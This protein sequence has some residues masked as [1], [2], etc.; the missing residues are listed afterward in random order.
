MRFIPWRP[1][2]IESGSETSPQLLGHFRYPMRHQLLC[3]S[4][5][6]IFQGKAYFGSNTNSDN[7]PFGS[8]YV[9]YPCISKLY[10]SWMVQTISVPLFF[11]CTNKLYGSCMVQTISVPLFFSC[12]NKLHGS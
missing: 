1:D 5:C 7:S 4:A 8:L 11:S 12:T 9:I 10:G 6:T 2:L 3:Q